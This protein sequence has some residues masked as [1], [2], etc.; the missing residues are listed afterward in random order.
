[1][2]EVKERIDE[3]EFNALLCAEQHRVNGVFIYGH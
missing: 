2:N 1:M 3:S